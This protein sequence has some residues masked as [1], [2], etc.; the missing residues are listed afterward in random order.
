MKIK[1]LILDFDGTMATPSTLDFKRLNDEFA[2]C[3]AALG[4][5]WPGEGYLLERIQGLQTGLLPLW[6]PD[7][8]NGLIAKIR[9]RIVDSEVEAAQASQLFSFTP[10]VLEEARQVGLQVAIV[11][12]N[13]A[14]AILSVFADAEDYN[15]LSRE[16][17]A[18]VKPDPTHFMAAAQRMEVAI[19]AC[20]AAGDHI[21]D[22]QAA[23]AAHCL[24]VGV[25]SG[26]N[27][28]QDLKQHGA[29]IVVDNI[30]H[31]LEALRGRGF[32]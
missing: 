24:G 21:M 29:N 6:G 30:A 8:T 4:V 31:L 22:M 11:S 10:Q 13:C 32:L 15:L 2:L 23:R 28:A 25:L 7:K 12:R 3:L 5:T 27:S 20:V 9:Q 18:S 17:V 19:D 26:L 14:P 1:G 16:R